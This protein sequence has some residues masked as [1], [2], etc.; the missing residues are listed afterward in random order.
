MEI[1]NKQELA[2]KII[3]RLQADSGRTPT[4]SS[5]EL[6]NASNQFVENVRRLNAVFLAPGKDIRRSR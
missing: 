4:A 5:G 2:A 3:A 6:K 1:L